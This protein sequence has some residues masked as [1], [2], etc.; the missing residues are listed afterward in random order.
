M[1]EKQKMMIA[2]YTEK[3]KFREA[4]AA[5]TEKSG[6]VEKHLMLKQKSPDSELSERIWNRIF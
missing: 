5:Q 3:W 2:T 4:F 1:R 6:N